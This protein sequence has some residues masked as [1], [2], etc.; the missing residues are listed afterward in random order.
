L[1]WYST[2]IK[3]PSDSPVDTGD[4]WKLATELVLDGMPAKGTSH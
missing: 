2:E 1:S 4:P 3:A